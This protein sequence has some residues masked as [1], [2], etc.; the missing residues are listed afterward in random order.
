MFHREFLNPYVS[1]DSEILDETC[2]TR[3]TCK[4]EMNT[5]WKS[6]EWEKC[7]SWGRFCSNQKPVPEN[8]ILGNM[9]HHVKDEGRLAEATGLLPH[10]GGKRALKGIVGGWNRREIGVRN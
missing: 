3:V 2:C 9:F 6:E 10:K 1:Y 5:F 4:G 8:Y 7:R